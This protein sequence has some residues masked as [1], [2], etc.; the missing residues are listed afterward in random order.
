L[1]K[2]NDRIKLESTNTQ[3]EIKMNTNKEKNQNAAAL[4]SIRTD[5]KAA[6]SRENG[7]KGGRPVGVRVEAPFN[8]VINISINGHDPSGE[9]CGGLWQYKKIASVNIADFPSPAAAWEIAQIIAKSLRNKKTTI[10]ELL[11]G[12][13]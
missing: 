1:T 4:G 10:E 5:K 11:R 3:E 13:K 2:P 8:G 7:K 9:Y 6:A 12:A